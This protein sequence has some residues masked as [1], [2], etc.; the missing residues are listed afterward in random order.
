MWRDARVSG[1]SHTPGAS[2]SAGGDVGGNAAGLAGETGTAQRSAVAAREREKE[3]ASVRAV[4]AIIRL[5]RR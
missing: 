3:Q 5:P 4:V 2:R 1:D